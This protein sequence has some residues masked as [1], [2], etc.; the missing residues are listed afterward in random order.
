[1]L[2][3][4]TAASL[5]NHWKRDADGGAPSWPVTAGAMVVALNPSPNDISTITGFRD[6]QLHL[7]WLSPP[8]GTGQEAGNS[9]VNLQRSYELQILNTP[10]S[11]TP[12]NNSAGAIYLQKAAD[13]NA[14]LGG[15]VWQ[16]YD[17]DF[18]AARWEGTVKTTDAR[19][20]VRWNGMLVH[21]NVALTAAT[22]ASLAESP[23]LHPLLLQAHNT[24]ASGA[25]RYRNVW[26]IP[27]VSAQERW[28]SWVDASGLQ[29]AQKVSDADPDGDGMKNLWEYATGGNPATGDLLT[30]GES[31]TPRM[32]LYDEGDERYL[33]FTFVRRVDSLDRGLDFMIETSPTMVAGSWTIRPWTLAGPPEPVGDGSLE[34]V[35]LRVDDSVRGTS[36]L[37][38]RLRAELRD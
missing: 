8:G 30:S 5:T 6:F 23:G 25:V 33:E 1:M 18:I 16:S 24:A 11:Q 37:F 29:G 17:I 14:S 20:S 38:A 35:T 4:G 19:V 10:A 7:E 12:A 27:K 36:Q 21:D 31:R 22:G 26:V 3:D 28:E 2:F 32:T 13:T 34:K 15:G 9:G